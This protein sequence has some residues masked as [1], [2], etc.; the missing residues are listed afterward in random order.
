[1][2]LYYR[3]VRQRYTILLDT[4][5]VLFSSFCLPDGSCCEVHYLIALA[6]YILEKICNIWLRP[7]FPKMRHYVA[8]HI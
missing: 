7:V 2:G 1:M 6:Y 5:D 8:K 4:E 3:S